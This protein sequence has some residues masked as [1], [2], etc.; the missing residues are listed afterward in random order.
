MA[1]ACR[2]HEVLSLDDRAAGIA[3]LYRFDDA[4]RGFGQTVILRKWKQCCGAVLA[5]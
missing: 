5:E 4:M 2:R 1:G 3:A